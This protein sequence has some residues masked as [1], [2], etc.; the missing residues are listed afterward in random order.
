MLRKSRTS[1]RLFSDFDTLQFASVMG[2]VV[3][4]VLLIFMTIPV[5]DHHG[6]SVDLPKVL[7][8]VAMR[9]AD[10]E[11]AIKISITRDGKAYLGT[12][13]ILLPDL[14]VKIQDRL[15]DHDVE[16]RVYIVADM[17]ARWDR[18][19]MVLDGVR[20]AGIIRVA[21]LADQ[22]RAPSLTR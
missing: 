6:G 9:G 15:K 10:R 8:P 19:E 18:V 22:R 2:M 1:P 21:F 14:P 3:F 11:D 12:E 4:V 13:Q 20:S 17:R 5:V 7:H 16:R